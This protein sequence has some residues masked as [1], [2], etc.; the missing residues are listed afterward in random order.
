MKNISYRLMLFWLEIRTSSIFSKS[1]RFAILL[2]VASL[3]SRGMAQPV[4]FNSQSDLST[5][6]TATGTTDKFAAFASGG[7]SNSGCLGIDSAFTTSTL[8]T[9]AHLQGG[10]SS[11][12][13]TLSLY[14]LFTTPISSAGGNFLTLGL[15]TSPNFNPSATGNLVFSSF[16]ISKTAFSANYTTSASDASDGFDLTLGGSQISFTNGDWYYMEIEGAWN[17]SLNQFDMQLQVYNSN[18]DGDLGSLIATQDQANPNYGAGATSAPLYAYISASGPAG[19]MGI[20]TIDDF[21]FSPTEAVP[22][23]SGLEML[24]IGTALTASS[25]R[26]FRRLA[27]H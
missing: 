17:N 24:V 9:D 25:V 21:Y 13:F 27:M 14:L 1:L 12:I 8:V 10:A 5:D 2:Y 3:A 7:I 16:S 20:G 11:P 23:P 15:A 19:S 4:D 22:E 18:S 26:S 6:F